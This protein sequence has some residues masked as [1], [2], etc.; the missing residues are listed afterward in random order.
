M[1]EFE[2]NNPIV[3]REPFVRQAAKEFVEGHPDLQRVLNGRIE[4]AIDLAASG[5]VFDQGVMDYTPTYLVWSRSRDTFYHV[6]GRGETWQNCGCP[7]SRRGN[8][9]QH[10]L[11]VVFALRAVKLEQQFRTK[12]DAIF[13]TGDEREEVAR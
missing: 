8:R 2:V 5:L 3:A 1:K 12:W 11:A 4:K 6:Q 13:H 10:G 7:D 9:C